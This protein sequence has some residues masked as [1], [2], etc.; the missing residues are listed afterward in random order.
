MPR[1]GSGSAS[2]AVGGNYPAV[3]ST[4]IESAKYNTLIADFLTM[5]SDSLAKD[6]QTVAT[7]RIPF[8]SGI[9]TDSVT[10]KTS[11]TGVTLDSV[12]LKDGRIDTTQGA[13]IASAATLNLETA[14][15]N[16]VD[17][18]GTVTVTAVTLSQGHWRIVRFTGAL[19]LT[20]GASLVLPGGANITTVAGDYAV[21]AGYAAG[22]VRCLHYLSTAK[23]TLL[24]NLTVGANGTLPMAR[25]TATAGLAYVA[26]LNKAIYGFTYAN[27]SGDATNDLDIAAGG[28]MDATGA[29]WMTGAA[30]TK[31]SDAAW[32]VGTG[33]GALDTGAVGNSDYHI[34]VIAR[35]DTGVIDYL[36]S[37]SSTAPTMPTNYDFKRLIGWFKRVGGTI[38]AFHTYETEG[39]GI[40]MNWD[41]PTLDVNLAATLG[42]ARRTDPVKVPLNFS[43]KAN[44][45]IEIDDAGTTIAAYIYCPDQTDLAPSSTAAPLATVINST[46]TVAAFANVVVR[47]S[48]AGLIAARAS[49]STVDNY[50]VSTLGFTWARRN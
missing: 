46:T 40:E 26:A 4:L 21:F 7:Q 34:W 47:T 13:D 28:A 11:D 27:N 16:V 8:A 25:S 38:V 37:L 45:N 19:T 33:A 5:F 22:V 31:Q 30:L 3:A 35:S 44:L 9:Q 2:A 50:R 36:F 32:A 39:G 10:E 23:G 18:T 42:T 1:N 14:T 24:P 48:A 41:S 6:G 20:N 49:T 12:L 15:G 17:V 43:T 29:Y